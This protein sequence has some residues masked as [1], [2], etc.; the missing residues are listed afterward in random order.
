MK[1]HTENEYPFG[2]KKFSLTEWP[3]M[4]QDISITHTRLPGH[5]A[6]SIVGDTAIIQDAECQFV[7]VVKAEYA[8]DFVEFLNMARYEEE[9]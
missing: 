3:L 7:A 8:E 9:P 2:E 4:E 5:R 6:I 1:Y